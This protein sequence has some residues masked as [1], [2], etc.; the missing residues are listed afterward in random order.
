VQGSTGPALEELGRAMEFGYED[1]EHLEFDSDLDNLRHLP[2]YQALLREYG[3]PDDA[4][5]E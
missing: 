5:L 4:D 2:A 3:I 1:F